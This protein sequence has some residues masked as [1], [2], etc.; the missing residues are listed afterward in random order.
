MAAKAI[1]RL[2]RVT[3]VGVLHPGEMGAAVAARAAR[4]RRDRALG[5]RRPQRGDGRARGAGRARG[6]RRRR[7]RSAAAARSCSRSARP[8]PRS[9]SRGRRA[10]SPAST[11][12]RTRSRPR[13]RG[14]IAEPAARFVDGG[15]VGPPPTEPGT[16]RLYLSGGEAARGRGA[17]RR[18]EPRRAGDLRRARRGVGAEGRLRRLDEGQRGAA[19]HGA[20][21]RAGRG[22]RGRAARGV[23]ALDPRARA[24]TRGRRALGAP[25]GLALDRRDGGDCAQHGRAGSARPDSTRPRPRSFAATA[26]ES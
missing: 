1:E 16:T 15:I 20:R 25:Q 11:S 4:A 21:A 23:A 3:V 10:A 5:V 17:V 13:R 14:P 8:T 22:S 12:T 24:A 6:R 26:E 7:T 2:G 9:T 18:H 19:A